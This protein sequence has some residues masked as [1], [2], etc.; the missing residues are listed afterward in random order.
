MKA[1]LTVALGANKLR[2]I[3]YEG[4]CCGG[5]QDFGSPEQNHLMRRDDAGWSDQS[6]GRELKLRVLP[7]LP[8]PVYENRL[9]QEKRKKCKGSRIPRF[10]IMGISLYTMLDCDIQIPMFAIH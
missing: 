1:D 7:R 10:T 2:S 5:Q 8:E 6:R 3:L 4:C 9:Y